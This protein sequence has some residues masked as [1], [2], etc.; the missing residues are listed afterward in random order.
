MRF[1]G[2]AIAVLLLGSHQLVAQD[3]YQEESQVRATALRARLQCPTDIDWPPLPTQGHEV[4][5]TAF[6]DSTGTTV[7]TVPDS[8]R[9]ERPD[10]EVPQYAFYYHP[11]QERCVPV[12]IVQ[13]QGRWFG[14][15]ELA[16]S[17]SGTSSEVYFDLLG[18]EPPQG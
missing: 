1:L 4:F 17:R 5:R 9:Y 18:T 15:D 6:E 12:I 2:V 11:D 16:G 3:T 14:Y 10:V 7:Y 13:A 8:L